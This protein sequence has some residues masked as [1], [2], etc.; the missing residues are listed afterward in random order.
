MLA[1][2]SSSVAPSRFL[3]ISAKSINGETSKYGALDIRQ[4]RYELQRTAQSILFDANERKQNRVC[5]CHR[6]VA[7]DGVPVFRAVDGSDARLGNLMTCGSVWSCPV[8]SA[9]ITESRRADMQ[10]AVSAWL[11]QKG[12]CLLN[13]RTFPHEADMPLAELLEKFSKADNFYKN[14]RTYK[15]IFGANQAAV[16]Q[17]IAKNKPALKNSD[18]GMYPRLGSVRS[19]EVT[20]GVNGWHPHVHEVLFMES[21]ELNAGTEKNKKDYAAHVLRKAVEVREIL[22]ALWVEC[23]LKAGL[24]SQD[25]IN[26]MLARAWDLRGGDYVSDYINKFGREPIEIKGWTIAMEATKANSKIKASGAVGRKFGNDWHYTPFQL[27]AF[28]TDGDDVAARLFKVFSQC[29]EGKRM[30]FWTNGLKDWFGINDKADE[31]LS[32]DEPQKVEEELLIRLDNEQ[33]QQIIKTNTRHELL[34]VA[35]HYGLAGVEK[36]LAELPFRPITH[37]GWFV[38]QARPDMTRFYH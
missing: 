18:M 6:N 15:Q 36:L 20:H 2:E 9:K 14:S 37:K 28:A 13:T 24:G 33:W 32:A 17:R 27:L 35:A 7:S 10:K 8:C 23:L 29:F 11:L 30:N 4:K 12:S 19:L 22:T 31:E 26:D 34:Q 16:A 38:S 1:S 3:G 25:K 5:S 21:D